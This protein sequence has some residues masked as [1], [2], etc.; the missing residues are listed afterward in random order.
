[1]VV[2]KI[3]FKKA[4]CSYID[5]YTLKALSDLHTTNILMD[6]VNSSIRNSLERFLFSVTIGS[7]ICLRPTL[8]ANKG[9]L[10]KIGSYLAHY[11]STDSCI[12]QQDLR[13]VADI[14]AQEF[15]ELG[16]GHRH[17]YLEG[18]VTPF[19]IWAAR[20]GIL[21]TYLDRGN[22]YYRKHAYCG[23]ITN[24]EQYLREQFWVEKIEASPALD[25]SLLF[26]G[27]E[28]ISEDKWGLVSK[29]CRKSIKLNP[30][31]ELDA[32]TTYRMC[33]E[34]LPSD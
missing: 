32:I 2:T 21:V 8:L 14:A 18:T 26:V 34:P 15:N 23:D 27:G 4:F 3:R 11:Q 19:G 5:M 20:R 25:S 12:I 33:T 28:H 10:F 31:P 9:F 6:T 13:M 17:L 22:P 29:L 1:M 16:N 24:D 30:L 7:A